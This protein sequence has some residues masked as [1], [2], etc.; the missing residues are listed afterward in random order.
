MKFKLNNNQLDYLKYSLTEE[1]IILKLKLKE[2]RRES[3]FV[4]IEIDEKTADEIR[5]WASVELQR[6][7]F[8]LNYELTPEG[9]ILEELID[10]FYIK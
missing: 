2:F 4:V 6:K 9:K 5:D 1:Q 10:L 7:G 8:N 3:Q